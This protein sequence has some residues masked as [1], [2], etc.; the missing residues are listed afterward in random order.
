VRSFA[1]Y[2]LCLLP[3]I[4]ASSSASAQTNRYQVYFVSVG[5]GWYAPAQSK[6]VHDFSRIAGANKSA[7]LVADGLISGGAE[8]GIE[9]TSDDGSFVTTGDIAKALQRVEAKIAAQ[10]P[11]NPLL[12]F[13]IASHGLSEGIAWSHFSIPGNFGY[14]GDPDKLDIDALSKTT[15]YAGSLVDDLEKLH[16]PFLVLL[17]SCYDGQEKHF[18]PVVLS[19]EVT[20]NL[21]DVGAALRVMNEF[22][23]TYPVLFSTTPGQPVATVKNPVAPDSPVYIG[24][25]ARR[26]RLSTSQRLAG[27]HVLTLATFVG[28][29]TSPSLDSS[30]TPAITHSKT[31]EGAGATFLVVSGEKHTIDSMLGSG[32]RMNVCCDSKSSVTPDGAR[33][34]SRVTGTLSFSGDAGEFISSGKSWSLQSPTQQTRLTQNGPGD[35]QISFGHGEREFDASFSTDSGKRFETK[36]YGGAERWGFASDGHAGLEI[37]GDGRACNGIVGSFS[38]TNIEYTPDGKISR[39]AASFVQRCDDAKLSARGTIDIRAR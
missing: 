17:D 34:S 2:A 29:M 35:L 13:Y 25:L 39:F 36:A 4:V 20:R 5:S 26:F 3:L 23:D 30:T 10:K 21:N 37:S 7:A 38:V 18:E 12:V 28:D 6:G 11:V 22:R 16:I 15:L 1:R 27:G 14:R 32:T 8:Y 31:P 19:A 24:P 33:S 9:L